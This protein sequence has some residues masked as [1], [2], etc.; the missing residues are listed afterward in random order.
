MVASGLRLAAAAMASGPWAD[1]VLNYSEVALV[2]AEQRDTLTAL[3][4]GSGKNHALL[5]IDTTKCA[6]AERCPG[7]VGGKLVFR[8]MRVT[9]ACSTGLEEPRPRAQAPMMS[10]RTR[11]CTS[12]SCSDTWTKRRGRLL[13]S[14]LSG[15]FLMWLPSIG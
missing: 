15:P 2:H 13:S 8:M 3:Y 6:D 10:S 14:S 1:P 12:V 11:L 9:R 7:A 5:L 4:R